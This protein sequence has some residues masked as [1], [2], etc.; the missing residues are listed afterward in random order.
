MNSSWREASQKTCK[1]R[2]L[3]EC[4]R[5]EVRIQRQLCMMY[6]LARHATSLQV[7]RHKMALGSEKESENCRNRTSRQGYWGRFSPTVNVDNE[8]RNFP[9]TT[10]A[11][12][13]N[14]SAVMPIGLRL[15]SLSTTATPSTFR[16]TVTYV[17]SFPFCWVC[18]KKSHPQA[19]WPLF[20]N[21]LGQ[22]FLIRYIQWFKF[23]F[24]FVRKD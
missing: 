5:C 17:N 11:H 19:Q 20:A 9:T 3:T 23:T 6:K 8:G 13:N 24:P 1:S 18:L 12:V 4:D 15:H 10:A 21:N 16:S 22:P 7:H 14:A 2:S